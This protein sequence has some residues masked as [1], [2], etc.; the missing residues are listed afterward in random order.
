MNSRHPLILVLILCAFVSTSWS[1]ESHPRSMV[2]EGEFKKVSRIAKKRLSKSAKDFEALSLY[3]VSLN[4][5]GK[6]K[7]ADKVGKKHRKLWLAGPGKESPRADAKWMRIVKNTEK[8]HYIANE[9]YVPDTK[10][11]DGI[12]Y[13]YEIEILSRGGPSRRT[14]YLEM[15]NLI[16]KFHVLREK[17]DNGGAQLIHYGEKLPSIRQCLEDVIEHVEPSEKDEEKSKKKKKK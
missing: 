10:R 16:K 1:Q 4:G 14:I 6:E 3:E 17:F 2:L 7:K 13:Y 9:Y 11:V 12:T 8:N 5:L 15:S